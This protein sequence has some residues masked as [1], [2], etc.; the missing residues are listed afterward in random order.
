MA[1]QWHYR[2]VTGEPDLEALGAEGW[3][4]VAIRGEEWL[5]KRPAPEHKTPSFRSSILQALA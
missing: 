3:E 4:L 5:F 1:E 2:R